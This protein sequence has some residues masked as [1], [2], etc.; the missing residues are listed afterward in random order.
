MTRTQPF[1]G[2]SA[3]IKMSCF[4]CGQQYD[5]SE[6]DAQGMCPLCAPTRPYKV[7]ATKG[8]FPEDTCPD[9]GVKYVNQGFTSI[10]MGCPKCG[11]G[12]K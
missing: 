4:K 1:Y 2:N 3:P 12:E 11:R 6:L 9:C 10:T 5:I 7:K 8:K